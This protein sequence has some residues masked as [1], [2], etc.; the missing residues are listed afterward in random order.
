M[1]SSSEG[2]WRLEFV[3]PIDT[4]LPVEDQVSLAYSRGRFAECNLSMARMYGFDSP[5]ELLGRTLDFMLP[6]TDASGRAYIASVFRSGYR[7]SDIEST[8]RDEHGRTA[9]FARSMTGVVVD[10]HLHRLWG[11]QRDISDRRRAERLQAHLAAIIDSADDA[12]VSTSLDGIIQSCNPAAA[13]LYGYAADELVGRSIRTLIPPDHQHEEDDILARV[14]RGERIEHLGTVRLRKDGRRLDI[15]LTVSPIRDG[16][17]GII[18][19]SKIAR[20]V[21]AARQAE[22]AQAYL[23]SIVESADVAIIAKNLDGVIQSANP[24]A[25]RVFGY[26]AGELIGREVRILI[27]PERQFE[28]DDILSR[29]RRGE[30]VEHFETVRVRKDGRRIDVSL[31]V[32]PV[33]DANGSIIGASKIARDITDQR[34]AM[35]A[36]AFLAAIVSSSDD[37]IIAKDLN[38]IIQQCNTTAERL[39]GYTAAELI[40]RP[41]RILIPPER[42]SEED[43]ILAR[44]RRGERIEHFETKRIRKDGQVLDISLT[45]SPIRDTAGAIIGISKIARD[46][47]AQKRAAAELAAQQAWFRITL[48][49]IGDAVI[50]ADP[51]G[52]VTFLNAPAEH[53][54]GWPEADA[55]GRP[56]HEVFNIINE[57]TR[58]P[59][60]NPAMLVMKLGHVVGLANH[61][62]LIARDGSE[63]PIADSAAPIRDAEGRMLGVVLVFRDITDERRAEE[64]LADQ[65]EWLE[66]TLQSIGDAVIATDVQGRIVFM[67]PVAEYLTGCASD[68]ARGRPFHDV[69][70]VVSEAGGQLVDDP[71]RRV[72]AQGGI[73]RF[74]QNTLLQAADG[75]ERAIDESG[76]PIRSRDGRMIGVVLVFRDISDRRRHEIDRQAAVAERERLLDAERAARAEA[77]RASRIKDEFVAMVSHELRT[78]LNAILGWTQLMMR[79]R[80]DPATMH[81]G[82]DIITRNTRLQAQLISDLLDIS[83]IV[84]GK[85]QLEIQP[86]DLHTIAVDAVETMRP[87]AEGKGVRLVHDVNDDA[88]TV[89]GDPA[90]LQQVIWNLL[91]NAVKFTPAGGQVALSVRRNGGRAEIVV[92]DSG[93]GIRADVLPY[94]FDRFHQA[95]RSIT[96]RFGGLGLG[97]SIVKHLVEL[98]GGQVVAESAGEGQGATFRVALPVGAAAPVHAP[99]AAAAEDHPPVAL[100]AMRILLVEDEPDTREFLT[101][102]LEDHGAAVVTAASA[103]EALSSMVAQPP[104][105]LISDIGLPDVDGYDLIQRVRQG[106]PEQGSTIPAIALTAYA[107]PEDRTRALQA[108]YQTHLAKPVEPSELLMTIASFGGLMDRRRRSV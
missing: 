41:V 21:N 50:A 3:P 102:L 19:V 29:L 95:D 18:G 104:D 26:T 105:L 90:R 27:P 55:I 39:F 45:I 54:T 103:E 89:A 25:E 108:G 7:A 53:L 99:A 80:N 42:Q 17:G 52:R 97:L 20:D 23:A 33:R 13:R 8:E 73:T 88:G 14:R 5:Q 75:T 30:R 92:A 82:L 15:S 31:T 83:R 62:I 66:T 77:E 69:F 56:L 46:I 4:S 6:S 87:E 10:G 64:A 11:T 74:G 12:I 51:H 94:I 37:A 2:I 32:S 96:R 72:L 78:P 48:S 100:D 98:H 43:D 63:R 91:S 85:L 107:R 93:A 58:H 71:V 40:G 38:G 35:E 65:R 24:A 47:T 79:G 57:K 28:E 106:F 9:H 84:S 60:E 68:A 34:R 22:R 76:A 86:V 81:R 70:R 67:N 49:S 61:T 1:E 16:A 44:M 59:V 36:Q 101:R